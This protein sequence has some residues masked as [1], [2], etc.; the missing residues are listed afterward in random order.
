MFGGSIFGRSAAVSAST[1]CRAFRTRKPRE[2][3]PPSWY[4][5]HALMYGQYE[6]N[7][8][9]TS[10]PPVKLCNV[11]EKGLY[12][13]ILQKWVKFKVSSAA[14][15]EI[16][17]KGGLD[18]YILLTDIQ[19]LGGSKS[20]AGSFRDLL[21]AEL[22]E[23]KRKVGLPSERDFMKFGAKQE[24]KPDWKAML[25]EPAANKQQ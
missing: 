8:P 2:L 24:E 16:D 18:E 11:H 5:K 21:L 12:S 19:D 3:T 1:F 25:N 9:R 23:R 15:R 10:L 14:L 7:K 6:E 17:R 4:Q 22:E 13:H 20:A